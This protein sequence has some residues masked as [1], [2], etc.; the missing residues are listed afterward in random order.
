MS[1]YD[2]GAYSR[3]Q[4]LSAEQNFNV[5]CSVF[6]LDTWYH[7]FH[8]RVFHSWVVHSR[9]VHSRLFHPCNFDR[10]ELSTPAISVA[11]FRFDS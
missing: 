3:M 4:F 6:P 10:A 7:V 2:S 9:V 5:Y 8:S 1:R 11:P